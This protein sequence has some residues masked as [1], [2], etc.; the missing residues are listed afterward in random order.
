[1]RFPAHG[2]PASDAR[3][4]G[5]VAVTSEGG[6]RWVC[7][8]ISAHSLAEDKNNDDKLNLL[9]A[10]AARIMGNRE[11]ARVIYDNLR[12]HPLFGRETESFESSPRSK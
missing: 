3:K 7:S 6:D 9:R 12:Y 11:Q 5:W 2:R 8:R 4:C 1:V 10:R